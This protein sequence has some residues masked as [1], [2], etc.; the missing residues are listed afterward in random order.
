M[1]DYRFNTLASLHTSSV[2]VEVREHYLP[3]TDALVLTQPEHVLVGVLTEL[4][5]PSQ[6]RFLQGSRTGFT[7]IGPVF[8]MP[9]DTPWQIRS[10]GGQLRSV[11][12]LFPPSVIAHIDAQRSGWS[13]REL[14]ACHHI[15]DAKIQQIIERLGQEA[16]QPGFASEI[17]TEALSTLMLV[18]LSR[19]LKQQ[20]DQA[21]DAGQGL[22]PWQ[23][24]RIR[25]YLMD[26][27]WERPSL[28]ALASLCGMSRRTLMRRFKAGTG[29]SLGRHVQR[30]Q[31]NRACEMLAH[32]QLPLKEIGYRLGFS[33]PANFTAAFRQHTGTT[34]LRYRR[35][36]VTKPH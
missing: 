31:F 3:R 22:E 4:P 23:M 2:S 11:T 21:S 20:D 13:P 24:R 30:M 17:V 5:R 34:P 7:N 9:A 36:H 14:I 26:V 6:G 18:E 27:E 16:A 15:P 33:S 1:H 25:E 28:S 32:S 10:G 29:E 35:A 8:F 12:C 19:Y